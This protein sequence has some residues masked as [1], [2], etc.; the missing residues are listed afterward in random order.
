MEFTG[1]KISDDVYE[2]LFEDNLIEIT[3]EDLEHLHSH[4]SAILRP[5]TVAEKQNRHKELLEN[6]TRINVSGIQSLLHFADYDDVII[7]LETAEQNE[8]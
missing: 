1:N 6:L 2:I 3:A 7:L 8:G 5:E 4:L